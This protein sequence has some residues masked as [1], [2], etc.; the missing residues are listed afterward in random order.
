METVGNQHNF[1]DLFGNES[2]DY[3]QQYG[4]AALLA[5][6]NVHTGS[7]LTSERAP[8]YLNILYRGLLFKRDYELE[9]LYDDIYNDLGFQKVKGMLLFSFRLFF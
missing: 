8:F 1:Q 6:R 4:S 9:P 3:F 2:L 7:L 5:K